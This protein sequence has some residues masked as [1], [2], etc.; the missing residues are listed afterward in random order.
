MGSGSLPI[1]SPPGAVR[2]AGRG[3]CREFHRT[4]VAASRGRGV[5]PLGRPKGMFV[6]LKVSKSCLWR[7]P[8]Q[9]LRARQSRCG[10]RTSTCCTAD[11]CPAM[12]VR[13]KTNRTTHSALLPGEG[14]V[15]S[16]SLRR[17]SDVAGRGLSS[18]RHD[19]FSVLIASAFSGD[20][21]AASA[22]LTVNAHCRSGRRVRRRVCE[23]A[24]VVAGRRKAGRRVRRRRGRVE[25]GG[26]R[27]FRQ[28]SARA[29][30]WAS[31]RA[32]SWGSSW[33][34]RPTPGRP[35]SWAA[36]EAPRGGDIFIYVVPRGC[37][38]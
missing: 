32:A 35:C 33:P 27:F 3:V 1:G 24:A 18:Q 15:S 5:E 22:A 6:S 21:S 8:E 36:F 19:R 28:G 11:S 20:E 31:L 23:Q 9:S 4:V 30:A 14:Y 37:R 10:V 12:G 34:S 26:R 2:S 13:T 25:R 16:F 29:S 17:H 7:A 38:P